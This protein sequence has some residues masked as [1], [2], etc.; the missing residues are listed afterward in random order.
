MAWSKSTPQATA[1]IATAHVVGAGLSGLAAALRLAASGKFRVRVH[2]AAG[3]AGGRCR[4][5]FDETL[6]CT[7]DNGNH[8]LLSGNRSALAYLDEIGAA[9]TLYAAP[10]P[11]FPFVDLAN[12]RRWTVRPNR[13]R[14]PWWIFDAARRVPDTQASDYLAGLRLAF[15]APGATVAECLG[16]RPTLYRRFWQPLAVAA[17]N[18]DAAEGAARLLWPVLVETFGRGGAMARPMIAR[19]GLSTSFVEPALK[20]LDEFGA[21][22]AFNRRLRTLELGDGRVTALDFGEDLEAL[23]PRDVAVLALPPA[24]A[25]ELLP[26]TP[27]PLES[28]A[29]VNAHFRLDRTP[30]FPDDL[31]FLGLVG[32]TAHWLFRRGAVVSVTVSAADDL[33]EVANE[34]IARRLWSDVARALELTPSPMP[35]VRIVK[36]KRATFAQTPSALALRAPTRTALA[37]LVLAGD[38]TDTGLPATIESAIRSGHRAATAILLDS[39]RPTHDR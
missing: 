9:G 10:E 26:G 31:P 5:F 11:A 39:R 3:Q 22:V 27:V 21:E 4:S 38:W 34:E 33:A 6:G 35:P 19:D 23:G 36:E 2:E 20:R 30:R 18:T 7:I 32:G 24:R 16:A 17:L 1:P 28:R 37:N 15:A 8:L 25:A 14:L 13:G 29:I 12:G